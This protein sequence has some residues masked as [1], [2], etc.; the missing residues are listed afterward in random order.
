[1]PPISSSAR[2]GSSV[3][4][5]CGQLKAQCAINRD[6]GLALKVKPQVE[7]LSPQGQVSGRSPPRVK[8]QVDVLRVVPTCSSQAVDHPSYIVLTSL[9]PRSPVFSRVQIRAGYET[10]SSRSKCG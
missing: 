5:Y 4:L 2:P 3:D 10:K 6:K 9:V 1:M 7:V 8:S